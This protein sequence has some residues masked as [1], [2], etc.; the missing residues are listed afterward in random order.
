MATKTQQEFPTELLLADIETRVNWFKDEAFIIHALLQ[1]VIKKVLHGVR[2]PAGRPIIFVLGP[3]GVGKSI[4]FKQLAE[5]LEKDFLRHPEF[6]PGDI[7]VVSMTAVTP[8]KTGVFDWEDFIKRFFLVVREPLINE[9]VTS[10]IKEISVGQKNQLVL[11]R[12]AHPNWLQMFEDTQKNRNI[13]VFLIDEAQDMAKIASGKKMLSQMDAI[14]SLEN[15]T[16]TIYILLG[17][18]SLL[19]L[20]D[21]SGQLMRRTRKVPFPRYDIKKQKDKRDFITAINKLERL[22]PVPEL[23]TLSKHP[24]EM[25]ALCLGCVGLLKDL[26][27]EALSHAILRDMQTVTIE[28][29]QEIAPLL[30]DRKKIQREIT[31]GEARLASLNVPSKDAERDFQAELLG[32][33]PPKKNEG[34]QDNDQ[35]KSKTKNRDVGLRTLGRDPVGVT[36]E[37]E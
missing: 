17:T 8:G 31:Q 20:S 15:Q 29:C 13:R 28:L 27:T 3:P 4:L 2:F 10:T 34:D 6:R 14:K 19:D 16:G 25:Y 5:M 24:K 23:P 1:S 36:P 30:E 37:T 11:V 12:D 9:K 18:Y 22:L 26:L 21:L 7:P 35:E 32:E 33:K